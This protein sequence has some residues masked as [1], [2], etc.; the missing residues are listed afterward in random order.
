MVTKSA[1]FDVKK[2]TVSVIK[3]SQKWFE[4]IF[5]IRKEQN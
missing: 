5:Q 3:V 2:E 1:C 4:N